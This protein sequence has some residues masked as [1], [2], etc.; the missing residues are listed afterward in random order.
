[1][2]IQFDLIG[3]YVYLTFQPPP[4]IPHCSW[5]DSDERVFRSTSLWR[6]PAELLDDLQ[7]NLLFFFSNNILLLIGLWKKSNPCVNEL[8]AYLRSA[9]PNQGRQR[10]VKA[11]IWSM[12]EE[13]SLCQMQKKKVILT[14]KCSESLSLSI[15][16]TRLM[17]DGTFILCQCWVCGNIN[18]TVNGSLMEHDA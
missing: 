13:S 3:L 2:I 17:P 1:M 4:L 15:V 16:E 5:M 6:L 7:P 11:Y 12:L 8:P 9:Q 14:D 18:G 10:A